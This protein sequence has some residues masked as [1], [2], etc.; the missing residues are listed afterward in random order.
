MSG[1]IAFTK[2]ALERM[3]ERG[4]SREFVES[5][6]DGTVNSVRFPSPKD[7]SVQLL[8]AKDRKG[9]HG[10]VLDHSLFRKSYNR[11]QSAQTGG[12]TL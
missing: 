9:R 11:A 3:S 4:A 5:A 1:E 10:K 6:I 12:E 2:H 8:T 7:S